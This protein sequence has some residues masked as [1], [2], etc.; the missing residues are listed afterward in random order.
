MA[1]LLLT[2]VTF[3]LVSGSMN[4]VTSCHN[5]QNI[6]GA[7]YI[8]SFPSLTKAQVIAFVYVYVM[9]ALT[10]SHTSTV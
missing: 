8:H 2:K 7:S 1:V 3:S 4:G 6:V 10:A 9:H 5:A